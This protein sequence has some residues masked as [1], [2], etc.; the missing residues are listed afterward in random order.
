M[1]T[2]DNQC[3]IKAKELPVLGQ[4]FCFVHLYYDIHVYR[5]SVRNNTCSKNI[6]NLI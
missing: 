2:S 4:L 3:M 6:S 1:M 5:I